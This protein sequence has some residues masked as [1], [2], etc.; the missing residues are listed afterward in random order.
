MS[1]HFVFKLDAGGAGMPD[2]WLKSRFE[3]YTRKQQ[4][5]EYA[6]RAA[7][8]S[9]DAYFDRLMKQVHLDVDKFN[10]TYGKVGFEKLAFNSG[11]MG[12]TIHRGAGLVVSVKRTLSAIINVDTAADKVATSTSLVVA[13]NAPAKRVQYR[14]RDT[15]LEDETD[16]SAIILGPLCPVIP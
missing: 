8:D 2:D 4:E 12:F 13:Y 11:A 16:A 3:Q 14:D 1:G 9:Y 15:W 5:D 7:L 10:A 6:R